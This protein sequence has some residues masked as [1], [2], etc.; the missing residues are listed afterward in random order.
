MFR[1]FPIT[2]VPLCYAFLY[3]ILPLDFPPLLCPTN[4]TPKNLVE[5]CDD[6]H[7]AYKHHCVEIFD[8]LIDL[9]FA[10]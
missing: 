9:N 3:V 5:S 1:N 8:V 7:L 4:T 6:F 10:R 2:L